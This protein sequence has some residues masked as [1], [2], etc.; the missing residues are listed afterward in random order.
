MF[1][2]PWGKYT[3]LESMGH[4]LQKEKYENVNQYI[5]FSSQLRQLIHETGRNYRNQI[6]RQ[7]LQKSFQERKKKTTF[8]NTECDLASVIPG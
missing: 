5:L 2:V 6:C 8:L 3:V 1:L 4:G 7:N